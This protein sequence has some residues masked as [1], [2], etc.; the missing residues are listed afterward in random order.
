[1]KYKKMI[2]K[3]WIV[4]CWIGLLFFLCLIFA[5]N[6][7]HFNYRMNADLASDAILGKLIWESRQLIPDSWFIARETRIISTPNIAGSLYG[8]LGNMNLSMG[9]ACVVMTLLILVSAFFC[10]YKMGYKYD[11]PIFAFILL[12]FP[13]NYVL[14]ELL[15]LFASYYAIHVVLLFLTVGVYA[16]S[17]KKNRL[18]MC[19]GILCLIFALLL[20]M[21]GARGILVIYGP[22]LALEVL[23]IIYRYYCRETMKNADVYISVWTVLM[24]IVSFIGMKSPFSV[25][26]ELSRNIR[27]GFSKLGNVVLQDAKSALGFLDTGTIGKICIAILLL[28]SIGVFLYI[29]YKMLKRKDL[30]IAD[31]IYLMFCV[32]VIL[33][34]L[35]V[36]FTTIESTPRYY[37]VL[38]L[39]IPFGILIIWQR[40]RNFVRIPIIM[41]VLILAVSNIH[42]VYFPIMKSSE[43]PETDCYQVAEYLEENQYYLAYATFENANTITA[44]TNGNVLVAS[45]ASTEKMDICKWMTSTKWY[46]PEIA[47]DQVTAYVVTETELPDFMYF[48]N[49][50]DIQEVQ[51]IGNYHVFASEYNYVNLLE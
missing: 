35:M 26:Q 36:A 49:G 29:I 6:I 50:K 24:V 13:A 27:K 11:Y 39:I 7:F 48:M 1:M 44:L 25:E 31:W 37:F 16:D 38:V 2:E 18:T 23:R 5:T 17:L 22:L 46:P 4:G 14:L 42:S 33:T 32:S 10:L 51:Q 45:V 19:G 30:L 3:A 12:M 15:Y 43:P 28:A 9:M 41:I 21:Q 8:I 40:T 47:R 20:G 34:E